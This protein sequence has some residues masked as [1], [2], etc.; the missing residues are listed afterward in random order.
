[1]LVS[2]PA[3]LHCAR[4]PWISNIHKITNVLFRAPTMVTS[5]GM[6]SVASALPMVLSENICTKTH[7][8]CC[9]IIQT[10]AKLSEKRRTLRRKTQHIWRIRSF[11]S[12]LNPRSSGK[13]PG[14]KV[15]CSLSQELGIK[16]RIAKLQKKHGK[17]ATNT[18]GR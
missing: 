14:S 7:M 18:D 12:D 13:S 1:M 6:V 9:K 8:I 10:V 16:Q 2:S 11:D 3:P 4:L 15:S 5:T 17:N